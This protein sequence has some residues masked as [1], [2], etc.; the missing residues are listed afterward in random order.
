MLENLKIAEYGRKEGSVIPGVLGYFIILEKLL[1]RPGQV[2]S[3]GEQK[4]LALARC[5]V[6]KPKS[7]LLDEPTE[8]I[9]PSI[10][11]QVAGKLGE[12]AKA[13][14]LTVLLNE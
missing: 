6:G 13:P 4:I 2:L 3:G 9:Q 1:E 5:L 11:D 12:L 8:V 7:F 14:N 10:I